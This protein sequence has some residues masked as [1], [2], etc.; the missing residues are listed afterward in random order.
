MLSR[1]G[2]FHFARIIHYTS[3][4]S[5]TL[6]LGFANRMR[7][8][9]FVHRTP[10]TTTTSSFDCTWSKF[11]LVHQLCYLE[12]ACERNKHDYDERAAGLYA[13]FAIG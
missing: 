9:V 7:L 4:F 3:F 11:S 5:Y 8:L 12:M 10:L 1:F 6:L 13:V 2:V